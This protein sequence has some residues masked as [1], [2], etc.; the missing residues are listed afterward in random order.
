MTVLVLERLVDAAVLVER[1]IAS[2]PLTPRTTEGDRDRRLEI[3]RNA[4]TAMELVLAE[5]WVREAKAVLERYTQ[6]TW[7]KAIQVVLVEGPGW[8][9]WQAAGGFSGTGMTH[10]EFVAAYEAKQAAI[11][12]AEAAALQKALDDAQA[13]ITPGLIARATPLAQTALAIGHVTMAQDLGIGMAFNVKHPDALKF[14]E[15]YGADWVSGVNDTTRQYIQG[16]VLGGVMNGDSYATVARKIAARYTEFGV[17]SP[18]GHIR[19]RAELVAVTEMGNAYVAGNVMVGNRLKWEGLVMEKRWLVT[20]D[21]RVCPTCRTNE[22]ASWIPWDE[23][24]PGGQAQPLGHPGCR[25]D[26]QIQ[27]AKDPTGAGVPNGKKLNEMFPPEIDSQTA[28]KGLISAGQDGNTAIA[29]KMNAQY[30]GEKWT[31]Q[32]VADLKKKMQKAGEIPHNPVPRPTRRKAPT[33]VNQ[34]APIGPGRLSP[35]F[36]QAKMDAARTW[37]EKRGVHTTAQRAAAKKKISKDVSARLANNPDWNDFLTRNAN[38]FGSYGDGPGADAA[39]AMLRQWASTS[40]DENRFSLAMQLAA[41]DEFGLTDA[42]RKSVLDHLDD[43]VRRQALDTYAQNGPAYRAFLR[44]MYDNTQEEFAKAGITEVSLVRGQTLKGS[45]QNWVPDWVKSALPT[46]QTGKLEAQA[47]LRPMSSFAVDRRI[48]RNFETALA[49]GGRS[50]VS[51]LF[52]VTVPANRIIGTGRTG[53][54]A[55]HEYEWVVLETPGE[56]T[57]NVTNRVGLSRWP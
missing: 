10:P 40:G 51:S 5:H 39:S 55:L 37:Y 26:L 7:A 24:F 18:L 48:G 6:A 27:R 33:P 8:N 31:A 16:A 46:P 34:G 52:E 44:A 3:M 43:F 41:H 14:I 30:P 4:E 38:Q 36:D 54:G 11:A 57:W 1:A 12:A 49:E 2:A 22:A 25:C 29:K 9:A 35:K 45:Q 56:M 13:A 42:A 28:A 50:E 21:N 17:P 23:T 53:F 47:Q 32:K 19:S 20:G 15:N